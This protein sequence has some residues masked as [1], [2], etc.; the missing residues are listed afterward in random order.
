MENTLLIEALESLHKKE[1]KTFHRFVNSP[2][3][4]RRPLVA[5]AYSYLAEC[6]WVHRVIPEKEQLFR[7]LFPK[8]PYQ[9]HKVR[10]IMS[11]LLQLLEQYFQY[12]Q[13]QQKEIENLLVLAQ[14]YRQRKLTRHFNRCIKRIERA[15]E[16]ASIRNADYYAHRYHYQETTYKQLSTQKRAGALNLQQT[17]RELDIFYSASK[18]R[19]ACL[20]LSHQAVYR[21]EY[22]LGLLD[23]VV[24]FTS[25]PE[26]LAVPAIAIYYYCYLA[27]SRPEEASAFFTFKELLF[28]QG[29][30]FPPEEQQDLYILG[31]NFCTRRYNAGEEAHL[32]SQLELYQHGLEQG[33]LLSDGQLSRYT[34]RNIVTLGLILQEYQWVEQFIH[35]YQ[36]KLA[37]AHREDMFNF[38]LARLAYSKKAYGEALQLLQQSSYRDPLIHLSAKTVLLKIFYELEEMDALDAQLNALQA[39]LRRR[40]SVLSYHYE[41]YHKLL[42]YLRLLVEANPYEKQA[43]QRLK[44]DIEQEMVVAEKQWLLRQIEGKG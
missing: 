4:N 18:L 29:F 22:D 9:D 23:E 36:A 26:W 33:F 7:H 32:S 14:S 16:N 37:S 24:R 8:E 41:N 25:Q 43:L 34:Y 27:L 20:T 42:K 13:Q 19:Q 10:V 44:K 35:Q 30:R 2:A 15:L 28:E 6:L 1:R 11:F 12:E 17:N 21:E 40:K 5:E 3:Y 39:F 31:I 38:C